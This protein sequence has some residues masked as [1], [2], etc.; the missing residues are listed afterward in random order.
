MLVTGLCTSHV[1]EASWVFQRNRFTVLTVELERMLLNPF[2]SAVMFISCRFIYLSY[3]YIE[4]DVVH[5]H[6]HTL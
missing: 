6:T 5:T 2:S 3:T 4:Q 1:N